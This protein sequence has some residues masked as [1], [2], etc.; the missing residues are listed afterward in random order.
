METWYNTQRSHS[1][2]NYLSPEEFVQMMNKQKMA[3]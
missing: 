3:A 1:A 2:L